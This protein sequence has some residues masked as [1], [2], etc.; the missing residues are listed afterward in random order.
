MDLEVARSK[1]QMPAIG[2][3]VYA[4]LN[5]FAVT[6]TVVANLL[7]GMGEAYTAMAD[8]G[9]D[10]SMI[11]IISN[12]YSGCMSCMGLLF[13]GVIL[14]A[15][16]KMRGLESYGLCIAG[17]VLAVLP[18]NVCC[19]VGLVIGIWSLVVL[20]REEVKSAFQARAAGDY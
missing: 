11:G 5:L 3:M 6:G 8:S 1:V 15:G 9:V 4:I 2:L 16:I 7:G 14:L 13:T 20:S 18:C 12:A 10:P 19:C 17:S